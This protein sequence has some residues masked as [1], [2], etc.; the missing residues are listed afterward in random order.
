MGLSSESSLHSGKALLGEEGPSEWIP[1]EWKSLFRGSAAMVTIPRRRLL[2]SVV[3]A[4]HRWV[5]ISG[6]PGSGRTTLLRQ[7]GGELGRR[8]RP[9]VMVSD[10][11]NEG[12]TPSQILSSLWSE[13]GRT[14][15]S[16][17]N[18]QASQGS[19]LPQSQQRD[20]VLL[21]DDFDYWLDDGRAEE[22]RD[23]FRESASLTAVVV[24]LN[25]MA[26][27]G[28][29][30]IT[31]TVFDNGKT[32]KEVPSEGTWTIKVVDGQ[33]VATFTPAKGFSGKATPQR[34]TVT[35]SNGKTAEGTLSVEVPAAPAAP[36][37]GSVKTPAPAEKPQSI[38]AST[39]AS[40]G[41]ALIAMLALAAAGLGLRKL[42]RRNGSD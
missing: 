24:T 6:A 20:A 35:D 7:L 27:P 23:I 31:S 8:R 42:S 15:G 22:L 21:V 29:A 2:R 18:P 28:S 10:S 40:V 9:H 26:K 5:N 11:G 16:Q 30:P 33:P 41:I 3:V 39:G 38:L 17:E 12:R 36:G 4:R 14:E 32:V 1:G 37:K 19:Q 34:Y 25:P 13:P